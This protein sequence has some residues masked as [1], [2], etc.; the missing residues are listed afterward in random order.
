M[1]NEIRNIPISDVKISEHLYPRIAHDPKL[2]E[3]Y[4]T[5]IDKLPPIEIN[6]NYK[7]I[8]GKHRLLAHRTVKHDTI[9]AIITETE[10]DAELLKLAVK[11]NASHG[12]Q[13]NAKDKKSI[14][15]KMYVGTT[16]KERASL[17][18]ELPD[19]FSVTQQTINNWTSDIDKQTKAER[20]EKIF[21]MWLACYSETQIAEVVEVDQKTVNNTIQEFRKL[22]KLGKIPNLHAE[23]AEPEFEQPIFDYWDCTEKYDGE[24]HHGNSNPRI[25]EN[26][27]Y[28]Y[29]EPY[30]IVVDPFAGGGSTIDL[31]KKRTRRYYT[32]DL[33]PIV[34][35]ENEIRKHDILSGMPHIPSWKDVRLV[36]LDP[37]RWKDDPSNLANMQLDDFHNSIAS[38]I[39]QFAKKLTT[40]AKISLVMS[41]TT[42]YPN[43]DEAKYNDHIFEIAH[44][45]DLKIYFRIYAPLSKQRYSQ[46]DVEWAKENKELL[47]LTR[48]IIIWEKQ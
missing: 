7:L 26:L 43:R 23:F 6:Q 17:K 46:D 5:V 27:L 1:N 19:V 30:D 39:K 2:V 38:I 36:Y 42:M 45:I 47:V 12:M 40:G 13:L 25:V 11:R 29:T 31:C 34:A 48:E 9:E 20:S 8:D 18:K 10:S 15:L 22:S 21:D 37:P 3:N 32:S 35:R 41:P 16:G 33:T 44:Q 14:A 28:L 24:N 4:A